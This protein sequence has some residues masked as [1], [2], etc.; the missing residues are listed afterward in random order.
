MKV[1]VAT[2]ETQGTRSSDFCFCDEGEFVHFSFECDRDTNDIDGGCGCRRSMSGFNSSKATT[3]FKIF[4]TEI[5]TE[6]YLNMLIKTSTREEW[7]P[8]TLKLDDL[9]EEIQQLCQLA[10]EFEVGDIIEKRGPH[11]KVRKVE[12]W[13]L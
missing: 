4:D 9:K 12:V 7:Y 8:N 13:N 2:K 6:D 1:F 5:N 3:T 10:N 11:F